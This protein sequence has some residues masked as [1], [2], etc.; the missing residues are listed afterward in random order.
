MSFTMLRKT[1]TLQC[2][3]RRPSM[4]KLAFDKC[5]IDHG[6]QLNAIERRGG[7]ENPAASRDLWQV[8]SYESNS[9]LQSDRLAV[10]TDHRSFC[11]CLVDIASDV[12]KATISTRSKAWPH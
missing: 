6:C 10:A 11:R 1:A 9:L 12:M 3:R 8:K 7:A 4:I 2:M 5:M